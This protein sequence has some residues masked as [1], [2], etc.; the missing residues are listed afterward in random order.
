MALRRAVCAVLGL[1]CVA[2]PGPLGAQVCS[3]LASLRERH[4]QLAAEV[5]SYTSATAIEGSFTAGKAMYATIASGT[6][7]N[8]MLDASTFDLRG[9]VGADV[10]LGPAHRV[11]VCPVASYALSHGPDDFLLTG[12]NYR[13][14]GPS[15]GLG[16]AAVAVRTRHLEVFVA[17]GWRAVQLT[18][19]RSG[20]PNVTNDYQL[21]TLEAGLVVDG[22]FT[23]RPSLSIPTGFEPVGTR[24]DY[25]VP[26][27]REDGEISLGISIGISFGG[28]TAKSSPARGGPGGPPSSASGLG[29]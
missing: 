1:A 28:N 20:W 25:A 4:F 22:R 12:E 23:V 15:V 14:T 3:G 2:L 13:Y 9:E 18:T 7:R 26:F 6:T 19:A 11:F 8:D 17:G 5:A 24:N 27:G 29:P 10:A 16:L 21:W